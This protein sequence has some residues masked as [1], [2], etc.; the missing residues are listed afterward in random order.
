MEIG[1]GTKRE[2]PF[3]NVKHLPPSRCSNDHF[4]GTAQWKDLSHWLWNH[5]TWVQI[6]TLLLISC[7]TW[8][9][10]LTSLSLISLILNKTITYFIRVM[11]ASIIIAFFEK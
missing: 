10:Y 6:P 7:V 11:R 1:N 5:T 8:F 2:L 3:R 9:S 4:L